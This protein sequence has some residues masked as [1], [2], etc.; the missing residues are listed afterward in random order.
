MRYTTTDSPLGPLL[1]VRSGLG[2]AGLYLTPPPSP[3]VTA[4]PDRS[5]PH[6]DWSRDDDGFADVT[7]QLAAYWA[8][9]RQVF[10]LPLDLAGSP[11]QQAVWAALRQIP[12]G[13][14]TSYG[15]LAR[16]LGVPGAS[17]AVG[18]ANGRNPVSVVVPCHRVVG[19]TGLLTGY[20]SGLANKRFLLAHE[21]TRSPAA[22]LTLF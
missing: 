13:S 16:Q 7:G 6:P 10:E 18:L 14:T 11:F 9:Q 4:G 19:S 1:L 17:R 20:S 5:R 2:L 15:A 3:V 8:G 12:Y 22:P 21:A